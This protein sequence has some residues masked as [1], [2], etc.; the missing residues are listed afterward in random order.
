[1]EYKAEFD[2]AFR[3]RQGFEVRIFLNTYHDAI[4]KAI[5][6]GAPSFRCNFNL[7]RL[8]AGPAQEKFILGLQAAYAGFHSVGVDISEDFE[9]EVTVV[10]GDYVPE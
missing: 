7:I 5:A 6:S 8:F 9:C 2:E 3:Q 4:K 10:F 1:M